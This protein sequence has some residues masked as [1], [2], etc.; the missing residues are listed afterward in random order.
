[1][2]RAASEV[3][4]HQHALS[5]VWQQREY[6][7]PAT[8]T[9]VALTLLEKIRR[10]QT[11]SIQ[12][13]SSPAD[14]IRLVTVVYVDIKDSTQMAQQMDTS[15]WKSVLSEAHRRIAELVARWGGHVGQY[16]G[17]GLLSFFGAQ[18]SGSDDALRAVSCALAVQTAIGQYANE[19]L[20]KHGIEFAARVGISTGRVVV[21]LI[22]GASKQEWLALGPSTNLAARLQ[23]LAEPG[24]VLL[25]SATQ[26]RVRSAFYLE[27]APAVQL[28]GFD[29]PVTYYCVLGRRNE[30]SNHLTDD[31][32]NGIPMPMMGREALL[33]EILS[34]QQRVMQEKAL[35][36]IT[37]TG[38]I[39]IGKS[40]LIQEALAAT[41]NQGVYQL[42]MVAHYESR[43]AVHNLLRNLLM[44]NSDITEDTPA[45]EAIQRIKATVRQSWDSEDADAVAEIVAHMIGFTPEDSPTF[46]LLQG[47]ARS[48]DNLTYAWLLRWLR[49]ISQAQGLMIVIDN[50]QWADVNS[51]ELLNYVT[52]ELT[53]EA[54]TIIA[55]GRAGYRTQHPSYLRGMSRHRVMTLDR[56][57]TESTNGLISSILGHVARIPNRLIPLLN[58]RAVGN[59][60]FVRELLGML[61][62]NGVF[63]PDHAS[64]DGAIQWRFNMLHYDDALTNLPDGLIGVIQARLDDLPAETRQVIQLAA[65]IGQTFWQ[66]VLHEI[67]DSDL[68]ARLSDL[69]ARSII[70]QNPDSIFEND[71][72]YSFR[73][74]L[75]R[76]VAYDMIPRA[77]REQFHQ[78]VA[79]WLLERIADKPEF[80][81]MLGDQFEAGGMHHAAL[82]TY[83]EAVQNR[84]NRGLY[85]DTLV[86]IDQGL[87]MASKV[88]RD[89]A[90]PVVSQL[91]T[92]RSQTL[93]SLARYGEA[94][95]A[96]Q[97]ALR[98]LGE[99]PEDQLI[100][101]R[102]Q[103]ARMLGM[104]YGRMGQHEFAFEALQQAFERLPK[105]DISGMAS[106]LRSFGAL[107]FDRGQLSEAMA[108]QQRALPYAQKTGELQQ[109]N[110]TLNE[111][112][113]IYLERG[114]LAD[115]LSHFEQVLETNY[116]RD[117]VHY[118]LA[119]LRNIGRVYQAMQLH[120]RALTIFE[121]ARQF[122]QILGYEDILLTTYRALG[123]IEMGKKA[124]G[125]AIL[126]ALDTSNLRDF[127][128][129]NLVE[130]VFLRSLN[131]LGKYEECRERSQR[132]IEQMKAVNPL[133][134][135][136]A[137]RH[138]AT[139][140]YH[141]G[142]DGHIEMLQE[143]LQQERLLGGCEIWACCAELA[144]QV[145]DATLAR[146]LNRQAAAQ[147]REIGE[148]FA[149]RPDL[150][151][152]FHNSPSARKTFKEA[153][154]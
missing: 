92:I 34:T 1:M 75:Y 110:A 81:A 115:A 105:Q 72:Q 70:I 95:A 104:A 90:L 51:I 94:S 49:A 28:K 113:I 99:L 14:E 15:D 143:S 138:L 106:V 53:D 79:N 134:A 71:V 101:A 97:S 122:Q 62:E 40:R 11:I 152:A 17:D 118:Q 67:N 133:L 117:Y 100:D 148:G 132:F 55:A 65:V 127:Y 103:A 35:H 135:A 136:R 24:T 126:D 147:L 140:R 119:D 58:E 68:E 41:A 7:S 3:A 38:E 89:V 69:T 31:H 2:R 102:V 131:M 23:A 137:L 141:L 125:A 36:A 124:E 66:S 63:Q 13:Q 82:F 96:S 64:A 59:P 33:E 77:K 30:A 78:R 112:G 116:A 32:I 121:E 80:Y 86:L 22:G 5:E 120:E 150:Q 149:Q 87:A 93:N 128:K 108:Y 107:C 145:P 18:R 21:G 61:F 10:L 109:V 151:Y 8:F 44:S 39:G 76:D 84:M 130:M 20:Q 139:A 153:G 26:S 9:K 123:L 12:D 56:L 48:L 16:L 46:S 25:D 154:A 29:H 74:S 27:A 43:N 52:R 73:H 144:R 85:I 129:Q 54:I 114:H 83:L 50:L 37:V 91:W 19:V 111:L 88:P 146:D 57:P 47:A 142:Q 98:L 4:Q 60:L 45:A 42:V 6:L